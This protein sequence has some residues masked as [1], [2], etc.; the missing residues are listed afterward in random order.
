MERIAKMAALSKQK[1]GQRVLTDRSYKQPYSFSQVT[2]MG[3]VQSGA[4][5]LVARDLAH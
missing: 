3:G 4:P 2:A 1:R 5:S